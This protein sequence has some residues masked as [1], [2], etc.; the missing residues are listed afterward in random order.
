LA[1]SN[2]QSLIAWCNFSQ[3]RLEAAKAKH[4]PKL[5][6]WGRD[7]FATSRLSDFLALRDLD[8]GYED[9][10][11]ATEFSAPQA[12][13]VLARVPRVPGAK[14]SYRDF[15]YAFE[16]PAIPCA[17]RDVPVVEG[18]GAVDKWTSW[19]FFRSVADRYFKVGE[20]D[21]GYSVKVFICR[22]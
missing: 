4:R 10:N 1:G 3:R 9:I 7:G 11:S 13:E 17:I 8:A 20:D 21:D 14:L 16:A 19:S 6:N 22:L 2:S 5:K 18:W 15:V 12:G